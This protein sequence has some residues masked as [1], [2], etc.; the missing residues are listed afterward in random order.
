MTTRISR[1]TLI[2]TSLALAATSKVVAANNKVSVATSMPILQDIVANIAG[3][4]ADVFSVLPGNAD[5]HTFEA[6]PEDMVK[7]TEASAFIFIGADLEPFV[8]TGGWRAAVQDNKIPE[9]AITDHV[10]LIAYADNDHDHDEHDD[11]ADDEHEHDTHDEHADDEHEHD[12][13]DEHA[14]DEH[15]HDDHAEDDHDHDEHD[16][17]GHSHGTHDPHIWLDPNKV[18]EAVPAISAFLAEIDPDNADTY[19]ANADTYVDELTQ[20]DKGVEEAL[21][22]IPED[23]RKLLLFHDA[24]RYFAARYDFEI[25]GIV[26]ANPDSEVSARE[27]ADL[28]HTVEESGV[29]VIFAEPQFNTSVLDVLQAEGNVEIATLLTDTFAEGVE[30]Y[31]GLMEYNR[32]QLV[33][34]LG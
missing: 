3:D 15:E 11:H 13:H 5:P 8:T 22:V 26:L 7:I 12:E 34:Y 25:I 21:A 18:I 28:Q 20:M 27:L 19:A 33:K 30:T 24:W 17:H 6:R 4:A 31:I 10:S 32:D 1:R 9:L 16:D 2:G 23:R 29:S 14:D